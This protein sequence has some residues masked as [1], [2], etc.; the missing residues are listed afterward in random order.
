MD[1]DDAVTRTNVAKSFEGVKTQNPRFISDLQRGI[2]NSDKVMIPNGSPLNKVLVMDK[3][4]DIYTLEDG[5]IKDKDMVAITL[6]GPD[7]YLVRD[8]LLDILLPNRG[9]RRRTKRTHVYKKS[10]T[11]NKKRKSVRRKRSNRRR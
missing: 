7:N 8:E 11:H 3:K 10:R 6:N 1:D 4:Y 5:K 9:G 2:M